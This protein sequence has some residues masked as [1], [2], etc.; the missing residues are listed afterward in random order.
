MMHLSCDLLRIKG[1]YMFL[2]L[3]AHPQEASLGVL[4]LRV[5]YV[6]WLHQGWSGTNTHAI[7]QVL[8]VMHL[9]RMSK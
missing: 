7:Y 5:C 8:L 1:L 9:L 4:V 6:S 3:L 2:A